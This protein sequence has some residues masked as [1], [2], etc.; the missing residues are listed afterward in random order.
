MKYIGAILIIVLAGAFISYSQTCCSGGVPLSGNIGFAGNERGTIQMEL[1][2]DVNYLAT[3]KN[4]SEIFTDGT[5]RRITQSILLKSGYQVTPW[6]AVDALFTYVFQERRI[7]LLK[8]NDLV[9]TNGLGDALLMAR[10]LLSEISVTG[11]ELQLGLGPKIPLGRSDLSDL[12]G[13]ALNAD[14][15]AGSG[16]WDAI[17]WFY[18]ARQLNFR[19]GS[20]LSV[21][22]VGRFNGTNQEYLG[23]QS[24]HFGNSL[25]F[26]L[27]IGDQQ[28]WGKQV[29]TPSVSLRYRNA[30]KDQINDRELENTGGQ[31]LTILP[32]L[33]WH[34]GPRTTLHLVPEL[35]VYTRVEGTQLSPTFRMQAGFYYLIG[36]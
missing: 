29:F 16:S 27:G 19:P 17:A 9:Q 18:M 25:Q 35:P 1:S 34:L 10:F 8:Q 22:M 31:W 23:S 24:Y 12:R 30:A 3:L 7:V 4:G 26:Y 11:T 33:S 21:R 15:Q 36:L 32:A 2:Y 13:I 28:V 14:L 5:R 6:L 20:V